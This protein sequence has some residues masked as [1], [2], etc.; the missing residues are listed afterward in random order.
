M[1]DMDARLRALE[2]RVEG[3]EK[4]LEALRKRVPAAKSSGGRSGEYR[5]RFD[6]LDYPER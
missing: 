2:E 5:D 3:L 4:K 1:N 6:A